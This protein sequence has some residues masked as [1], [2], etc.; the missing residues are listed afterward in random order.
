MNLKDCPL[1]YDLVRNGPLKSEH[2]D[3]L[4]VSH[5]GFNGKEPKIWCPLERGACITPEGKRSKFIVNKFQDGNLINKNNPST[6]L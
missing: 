2:V 3:L 4:K 5:C 6:I 1:I